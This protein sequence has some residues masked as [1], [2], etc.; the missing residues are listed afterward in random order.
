MKVS[1]EEMHVE[2]GCKI[3]NMKKSLQHYKTQNAHLNY[4]NDQLVQE[5][6]R[7]REDL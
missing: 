1:K 5:N 2:E 3:E 6:R 7:L 4:F